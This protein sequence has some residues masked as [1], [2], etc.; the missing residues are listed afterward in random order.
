MLALC[1]GCAEPRPAPA[2]PPPAM[3]AAAPA[4]PPP[5]PAVAAKAPA[6]ASTPVTLSVPAA[7][8]PLTS[9][10]AVIPIGTRLRAKPEAGSAGIPFDLLRDAKTGLPLEGVVAVRVLDDSGAFVEVETV[11]VEEG[12]T[13]FHCHGGGHPGLTNIALR[14]FVRKE[15]L[16]KVTIK[17][18]EV[19]LGGRTGVTVQP[20]VHVVAKGGRFTTRTY[21]ELTLR[22][23]KDAVGTSYTPVVNFAPGLTHKGLA[24]DAPKSSLRLGNGVTFERY[25][26]AHFDAVEERPGGYAAFLHSDCIRYRFFVPKRWMIQ[27]EPMGARNGLG[28][29]LAD[30]PGGPRAIAG[31]PAYWES[32]ERAGFLRTDQGFREDAG[33]RAGRRCLRKSMLVVQKGTGR[34][35]LPEHD[36]VL[37]FD[38]AHVVGDPVAAA[39]RP[40][41]S[42]IAKLSGKTAG[43][44][45]IEGRVTH[46][47]ACPVCPPRKI[48]YRCEEPHMWFGDDTA[49]IEVKTTVEENTPSGPPGSI[50][51]GNTLRIVVRARSDGDFVLVRIES[52]VR[53]AP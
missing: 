4:P 6:D 30:D 23:S 50:A 24:Q 27:H 52:L 37:C 34:P 3:P 10:Y 41:P 13:S 18:S 36:F 9:R 46:I 17:T 7:P 25:Q 35:T 22:L 2:P 32:G 43:E 49:T 21:P 48:C 1:T 20:G 51:V 31:A 33:T 11:P 39:P 45:R 40:E 38:P 28:P 47:Y 14:A 16:Q 53:R 5:P 8:D 26:G 15:A 19:A 12:D 42:K 29:L 44:Y